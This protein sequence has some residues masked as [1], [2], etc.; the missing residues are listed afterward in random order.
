MLEH[1]L[2][3][4]AENP[5]T[6]NIEAQSIAQRY[7]LDAG[8]P[9]I[10]P[11]PYVK[12]DPEFSRRIAQAFIDMPDSPDDPNVVAAYEQLAKEVEAQFEIL[13]VKVLS[14]TDFGSYPYKTSEDMMN[15]ILNNR[16]M[17]VYDGG[18]D[19]S[20][21]SRE[22]NFKF[23]AVHDFFGHAQHGFAF[24][25]RGEEN[26]WLEY[27][28]MFS[29]L[30]RLALTTETRGQNNY[31]NA[32]PFSHLPVT[33][34]PYA[35]QKVGILP[36]EFNVH[37]AFEQAYVMYP[38]FVFGGQQYAASNPYRGEK[39]DDHIE[40]FMSIWKP[41]ISVKRV[42][43]D[44]RSYSAGCSFSYYGD[45]KEAIGSGE[46][47][48]EAVIDAMRILM[49]KIAF[50]ASNPDTTQFF[51]GFEPEEKK[52]S[53]AGGK[54]KFSKKVIARVWEYFDAGQEGM[55]WYEETPKKV[56]A[57]FNGDVDRTN[58]FIGFLAATS[59]L[60][61]IWA[62]TRLA[63]KA[64][65]QWDN[66]KEK[67]KRNFCSTAV[68]HC[69]KLDMPNHEANAVR[70]VC[71]EPLS[72]PKVSAF[73]RNLTEKSENDSGAVTVDTWMLRAFG[74]RSMRAKDESGAPT[75]GE[76]AA[77][78]KKVQELAREAKVLPRQFQAAVWVGIKNLEGD[79]SD[80]ADPFEA[81]LFR[82]L[83]AAA[84]QE[85]FA[86]AEGDELQEV[87]DRRDIIREKIARERAEFA[88][89]GPLTLKVGQ[90]LGASFNPTSVGSPSRQ[91]WEAEYGAWVSPE[92]IIRW[93][94]TEGHLDEGVE[95]LSELLNDTVT[96]STDVY[97][98]LFELGCMRVLSSD[99][100]EA[101]YIGID[102]VDWEKHKPLF[103]R[104]FKTVFEEDASVVAFIGDFGTRPVTDLEFSL[105][106]IYQTGWSEGVQKYH[107]W[108][109]VAG[110]YDDNP[111]KQQ[112]K[113]V[114]SSDLDIDVE[115]G[116]KRMPRANAISDGVYYEISYEGKPITYI[117]R[118][119]GSMTSMVYWYEVEPDGGLKKTKYAHSS[120]AV[121]FTMDEALVKVFDKYVA[122]SNPLTHTKNFE[123]WFK[124]L[125]INVVVQM[126]PNSFLALTTSGFGHRQE[127][128][129]EVKPLDE[130][131][132]Y[133]EK[134]QTTVPPFLSVM[135]DGKN[136][137]QGR[138]VGH[139]GRHRA[140]AVLNNGE[141]TMLVGIKIV[142]PDGV[143]SRNLS[144]MDMPLLWNG[145]YD[146]NFV[147]DV[148]NLQKIVRTNVQFEYQRDPEIT[149]GELSMQ[150]FARVLAGQKP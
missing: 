10:Q 105:G 33:E 83:E 46:T 111:P 79:P 31:V 17:I 26:A 12:V 86:F 51:P 47:R 75:A 38:D 146:F 76:Y 134:G 125:K 2:R 130:Y 27:S 4:I 34:R 21:L 19:H 69:F 65:R 7:V 113:T 95:I 59:P 67:K 16:Q 97:G 48:E 120:G 128:K 129:K 121:G 39:F 96:D 55:N 43:D 143:P 81:A 11:L 15:D 42:T 110:I 49:D 101:N 137:D 61:N 114:H 40:L 124:D 102:L 104:V 116:V 3:E 136:P 77:I 58:L 99:L 108:G 133:I 73:F 103:K 139:E 50:T 119:P 32:G 72:G 28:K 71:G 135:I 82:Q 148:A 118:E 6:P 78:E 41:K 149:D 150:Q 126:D 127:I 147:F 94:E 106:E 13:P 24:G 9:P 89:V 52:Q 138:V 1:P 56:Y 54:I 5:Y 60:R 145:E 30:A 62:N 90:E 20:I 14:T 23:R 45:L 64:M 98:Q 74:L 109:P 122:G 36:M 53:R 29:P 123:E 57:L 100:L 22:E 117:A 85:V 66:C 93:V 87:K 63:L 91:D 142:T 70:V 25:P 144:I 132:E 35:E 107:Q 18:D 140:A 68:K 44:P 84:G 112:L 92:G 115:I 8:F 37:P 80:R 88:R 131:N 141:K